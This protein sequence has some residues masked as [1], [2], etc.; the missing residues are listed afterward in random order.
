MLPKDGKEF[1]IFLKPI[2]GT[3]LTIYSKMFGKKFDSN[4]KDVWMEFDLKKYKFF[5]I[6]I[7]DKAECRRTC[8][9]ALSFKSVRA[10]G[11]S[12][13][14]FYPVFRSMQQILLVIDSL[15]TN[16]RIHKTF[17]VSYSWLNGELTELFLNELFCIYLIIPV[18]Y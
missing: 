3:R 7:V 10:F 15:S 5:T 2:L 11:S 9:L 4:F 1:T 13:R 18:C 14:R 8:N 17:I 16:V 6:S 12:S